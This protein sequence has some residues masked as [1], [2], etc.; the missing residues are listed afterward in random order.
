VQG[1]RRSIRQEMRRSL[2]R[3]ETRFNVELNVAEAERR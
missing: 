1:E 2:E 3:D